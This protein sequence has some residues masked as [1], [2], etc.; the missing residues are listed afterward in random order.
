M[1]SSHA[2]RLRHSGAVH[3][4]ALAVTLTSTLGVIS[5]AAQ[6]GDKYTARLGWVPI[7]GPADRVNVTG[8]GAATAVLSGR[9]LTITGSFEGLAGPA[10]VAR[11]HKGIAKGARGNPIA[12][13]TITKAA[14]GMISGSVDLMP[15]Q[16]EAL[17]QGKL[18]VQVHSAK[19]V[20]P[21]GSNLWGWLMK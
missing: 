5:L 20:A 9:K 7:A 17:K 19:G 11:L 12:D 18:Y 6:S 21:D 13:L 4:I 8:K 1:I 3:V 14:S 2:M 15:D 10:T 16:I